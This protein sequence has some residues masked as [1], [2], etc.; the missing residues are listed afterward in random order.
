MQAGCCLPCDPHRPTRAA[1]STRC[2]WETRILTHMSRVGVARSSLLGRDGACRALDQLVE[3]VR[4]GRGQG[5][6][7]LTTAA[8]TRRTRH[9]INN[10]R[11]DLGDTR[12]VV[13]GSGTIVG[14]FC[15]STSSSALFGSPADRKFNY[16]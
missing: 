12:V 11:H 1:T 16:D 7:G 4:A 8:L 13:R 10:D 15:H 3:A 2:I 14:V 6:R 5:P 9:H